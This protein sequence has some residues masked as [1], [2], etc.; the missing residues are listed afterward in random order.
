[1]EWSEMLRRKTQAK[2]SKS[3][4]ADPILKLVT[5]KI[6]SGHSIPCAW[7]LV[8][9]WIL[10]TGEAPS[11][12]VSLAFPLGSLP[13]WEPGGEEVNLHVCN[14]LREAIKPELC[15]YTQQSKERQGSI[16]SISRWAQRTEVSSKVWVDL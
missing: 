14:P 11:V 10:C 16:S 8:L 7:L 12:T 6:R 1:M 2:G 5:C 3:G 15:N 4:A 9:C 13:V